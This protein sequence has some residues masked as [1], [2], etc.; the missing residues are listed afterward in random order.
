MSRFCV[1]ALQKSTTHIWCLLEGLIYFN[2]QTAVRAVAGNNKYT[3]DEKSFYW[4]LCL[5]IEKH[6]LCTTV[7]QIPATNNYQTRRR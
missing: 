7:S 6:K 5:K 2:R 4:K 1:P 3:E